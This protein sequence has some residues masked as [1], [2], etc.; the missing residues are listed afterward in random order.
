MTSVYARIIADPTNSDLNLQY[1][2]IAEGRK[3]YRK[4]LAAYERVLVNDPT[5]ES[6]KRGLARIRRILQPSITQTSLELGGTWESNPELNPTP[7]GEVSAYGDVRIKDERAIDGQRWRTNLSLYGEG[8]ATFSDLNYANLNGDIGPLIDLGASLLTFR[9]AVGAGAA[10]FDGKVYYGDVNVSGLLEGYLSGAYQ[11]IRVRAGYRDYNPAFSSGGT[12][13]D[14]TGKYSLSNLIG[15]G[16]VLSLAPWARWSGINGVTNDTATDFATGLYVEGGGTLEYSRAFNDVLTAA[17][18]ITAS[19]RYYNN[20]G[21]GHRQDQNVSPGASLI[22][23]NVL[24]PQ[25]DLRFDYSYE[26]NWSNQ[27]G[28]TWQDQTLTAAIVIRR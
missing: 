28:H 22:L 21:T 13:A 23:T 6:A 16:D 26:W 3:E 15:E 14:I 27:T 10:Y 2:L 17:V 18:N 9:P 19:D 20:I 1:A 4:A 8:H 5:N 25:T 24:S 7:F 11:W 12:Y